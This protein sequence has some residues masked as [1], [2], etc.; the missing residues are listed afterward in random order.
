MVQTLG[1]I[2]QTPCNFGT[3]LSNNDP[4]PCI[5]DVKPYDNATIFLC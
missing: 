3:T 4:D 1:V 5:E 2:V